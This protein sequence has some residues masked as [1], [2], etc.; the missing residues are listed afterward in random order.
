MLIRA[1]TTEMMTRLYA[2]DLKMGKAFLTS[3]S[4]YSYGRQSAAVSSKDCDRLSSVTT[5]ADSI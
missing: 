4:L 1:M 3:S 2:D 5:S